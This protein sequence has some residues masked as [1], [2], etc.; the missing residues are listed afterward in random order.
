MDMLS[1]RLDYYYFF[2]SYLNEELKC[3]FE[4]GLQ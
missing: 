4:T 3:V 1:I 2:T